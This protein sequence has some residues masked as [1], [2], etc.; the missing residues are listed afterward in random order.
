MH[1]RN[2][3]MG[4]VFS[5]DMKP[6]PFPRTTTSNHIL[7]T[8]APSLQALNNNCHELINDGFYSAPSNLQSIATEVHDFSDDEGEEINV[9]YSNDPHQRLIM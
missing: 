1:F 9:D 6:T 4:K 2:N 5:P 8:S 3:E 7:T